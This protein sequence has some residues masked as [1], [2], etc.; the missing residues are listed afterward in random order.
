MNFINSHTWNEWFSRPLDRARIESQ[1][2]GW[3]GYNPL[4][5]SSKEVD[6]LLGALSLPPEIAISGQL[7]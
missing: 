3:S 1:I 5:S 6:K 2:L 4:L 7:Y